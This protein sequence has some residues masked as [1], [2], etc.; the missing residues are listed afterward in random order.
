MGKVTTTAPSADA[1][2]MN[3]DHSKQ[4][5]V[6][7]DWDA[8]EYTDIFNDAE[9]NFDEVT[10]LGFTIASALGRRADQIVIDAMKA[11]TYNATITAAQGGLVGT[12]IGGVGTSLNVAKLR[13]AKSYLDA[14]EVG[15][16]DRCILIEE[17]GLEALLGE[18]EVTSSDY[19]N[20][21]ALV[22]GDVNT[23]LGFEFITIGSAREEGGL[24]VNTNVVDAFVWQK[25]SLGQAIG[26]DIKTRVGWSE[27]KDSWKST[28]YFKGGAVIRDNE[29]LV[30]LQYTVA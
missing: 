13:K 30:K 17:R 23:F 25:S 1:I 21:K 26:I 22:S 9:V 18:T 19:A 4:V 14:R 12:D 24:D 15:K 2:P 20:V 6:L 16:M 5:A 7:S 29:G 11:G 10:E 28:G 8:P 3:I 27:D